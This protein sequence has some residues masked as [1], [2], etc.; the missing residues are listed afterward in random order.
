MRSIAFELKD[1]SWLADL[2]AESTN[3]LDQFPC[4]SIVNF[5]PEKLDEGFQGIVSVVPS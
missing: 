2:V 5:F 3:G 4:M 1:L